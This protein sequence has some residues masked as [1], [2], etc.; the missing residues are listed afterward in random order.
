M[1]N[2]ENLPEVDPPFRTRPAD[3]T[4]N[5]DRGPDWID[6]ETVARLGEQI[7]K[8]VITFPA[9]P[10]VIVAETPDEELQALFAR[11]LAASPLAS[12]FALH[13][14]TFA[15]AQAI[16]TLIAAHDAGV[17]AAGAPAKPTL[18]SVEI[19]AGNLESW[20]VEAS[21]SEDL[22]EEFTDEERTFL[23][24]QTTLIDAATLAKLTGFGLNTLAAWRSAQV[25]PPYIKVSNARRSIRYPV[26]GVL[27]W[28]YS[29]VTR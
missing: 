28:I 5:L 12:P 9:N 2:L 14:R 29:M 10:G 25:G 24:R 17:T 18:S 15:L 27:G 20:L 7:A 6:G 21:R 1:A 23:A 13:H 8:G 19:A 26:V 4:G 3:D 11:H 22:P 16:F